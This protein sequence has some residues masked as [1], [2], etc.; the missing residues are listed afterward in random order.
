MCAADKLTVSCDFESSLLCG[1]TSTKL[2]TV[3]W[4]RTV[5]KSLSSSSSGLSIFD[6]ITFGR[7]STALHES[8]FDVTRAS[9][10]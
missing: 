4:E 7:G 3:A 2:G 1:Y 8:L 10:Q 5:N 6:F 9:G